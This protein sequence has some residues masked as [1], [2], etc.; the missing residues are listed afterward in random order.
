MILTCC[1]VNY[2]NKEYVLYQLTLIL[3]EYSCDSWVLWTN[4]VQIST[5]MDPLITYSYSE[6]SLKTMI[7][8][9]PHPNGHVE[10]FLEQYSV[11]MNQCSHL[12]FIFNLVFHWSNFT[13]ANSLHLSSQVS[14]S[15]SIVVN[16]F[17]FLKYFQFSIIA[18]ENTGRPEELSWP[19]N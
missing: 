14:N 16:P 12:I 8:P 3:D 13:H 2:H 10:S 17:F 11:I 18:Q 6:H 15:F 19:D 9:Q 1:H 7:V 5:N 4:N